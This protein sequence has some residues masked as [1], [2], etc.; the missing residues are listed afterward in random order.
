LL[1]FQRT[2]SIDI[3][4]LHFKGFLFIK[5][6]KNITRQLETAK[7]EIQKQQDRGRDLPRYPYPYSLAFL[8]ILGNKISNIF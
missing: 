2:P 7:I 4:A 3:I 1:F 5:I 8:V 6:P